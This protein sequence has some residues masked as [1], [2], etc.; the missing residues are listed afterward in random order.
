MSGPVVFF[1]RYFTY[2]IFPYFDFDCHGLPKRVG[3][4]LFSLCLILILN[5]LD[6]EMW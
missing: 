6:S 4:V 1:A 3:S 2:H 5:L